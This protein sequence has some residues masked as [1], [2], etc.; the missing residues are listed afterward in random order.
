[1]GDKTA[2]EWCDKTFNP[3]WGCTKV[4]PACDRCYAETFSRRIGFSESGSK[5][6]IW[7]KDAERRFF[8]DKHWAEPLKWDARLRQM[9]VGRARWNEPPVRERVFCGSMCDV[10]ED[11]RD[12]D[13]PRSRLYDLIEATPS[14]DW[15]LLTKRPQN[16]RRFLPKEWLKQSRPNVWLMT[17]VESADYLWRIDALK[18]SPAL[19]H[20]LSVEPLLGPMPTLGEYLDGIEWVIVGGESGHGARPVH[21]DWVR[22]IRDQCA[23]AGVPFLFKQWG[24]WQNGSSYLYKRSLRDA[25]VLNDGT[26]YELGTKDRRGDHF[27]N[28]PLYSP[29]MMARVGKKAAG[30]ILDG[31]EHNGFPEVA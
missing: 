28:W 5:I 29:C 7:G 6:P 27:E 16:F 19:V 13:A 22:S 2:I 17:T 4:S 18:G 10:M 23:A 21:P 1:M 9:N 8:G 26:V 25:V 11:R 12:L 24:E 20:G 30:R 3:W 31:V 15:L 14:L